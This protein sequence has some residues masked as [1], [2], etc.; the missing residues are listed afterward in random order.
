MLRP[1]APPAPDGSGAVSAFQGNGDYPPRQEVPFSHSLWVY[2]LFDA[3]I[4]LVSRWS[5]V[6]LNR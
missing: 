5:G 3:T 1:Q 6:C 4:P 2:P